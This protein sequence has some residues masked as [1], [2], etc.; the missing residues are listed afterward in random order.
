MKV[1]GNHFYSN[2][3][4]PVNDTPPD[5]IEQ[6]VLISGWSE[7]QS[8]PVNIDTEGATRKLRVFYRPIYRKMVYPI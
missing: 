4:P 7:V 3:S 8:N 1:A 6:N 2:L 5:G